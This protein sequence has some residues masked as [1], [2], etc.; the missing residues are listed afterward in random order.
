MDKEIDV[1]FDRKSTIRMEMMALLEVGPMTV[2]DL[3]QS[4]SIMEKEVFDH[5]VN[6]E[7]S[8]KNKGKILAYD[9]YRCLNCGFEFKTRKKLTKPGKCPECRAERIEPAV[10]WIEEM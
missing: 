8:L 9:P 3:S 10:F 2:R 6:V 4:L 1:R 7:K 5:L